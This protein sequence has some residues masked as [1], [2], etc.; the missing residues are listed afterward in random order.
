VPE[1]EAAEFDPPAPI[2]RAR[3]VG[4]TGS[5]P[6]VPLLIDSGADVSVVPRSAANAVGASVVRSDAAIELLTGQ[7][8]MLDRTQLTIEFLHFRFHGAFLV[9]DSNY[10]VLGRNILN[11]L[12]LTLDGPRLEWSIAE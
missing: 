7:E 6:D 2:V 12:A 3:I 10:G 9:V 5:H 11:A 8:I 4:P 1:Y